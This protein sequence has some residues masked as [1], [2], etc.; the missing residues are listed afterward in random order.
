MALTGAVSARPAMISRL[1]SVSI[2][3]GL[4][5]RPKIPIRPRSMADPADVL[6]RVLVRKRP[7]RPG[8]LSGLDHASPRVGWSHGDR[9]DHP[10][11]A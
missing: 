8:N 7:L 1:P 10:R 11:L 3:L 6:V 2:L 9:P 4:Y 5:I